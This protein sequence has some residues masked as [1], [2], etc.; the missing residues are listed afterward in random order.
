MW[1]TFNSNHHPNCSWTQTITKSCFTMTTSRQTL[2]EKIICLISLRTW[3]YRNPRIA[4]NRIEHNQILC[5][6]LKTKIKKI[7]NETSQ[8]ST[9]RVP[10]CHRSTRV[11]LTLMHCHHISPHSRSLGIN[12]LW[13]TI[14]QWR[15]RWQTNSMTPPFPRHWFLIVH[16]TNIQKRCKSTLRSCSGWKREKGVRVNCWTRN[17]LWWKL[18]S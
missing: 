5:Q 7:T 9:H 1:W 18:S 11:C 4:C 2:M 3:K 10:I 15:R 17:R 8:L 16:M 6:A 14:S 13:I 12:S